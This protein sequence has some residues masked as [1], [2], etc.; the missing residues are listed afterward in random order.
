MNKEISVLEKRAELY[1]DEMTLYRNINS[2]FHRIVSVEGKNIIHNYLLD[3]NYHRIAFYGSGM[4]GKLLYDNL[5][6]FRDIVIVGFIDK[7]RNSEYGI[8]DFIDLGDLNNKNIDL[9]I[10]TPL[11]AGVEI[12]DELKVR[13]II[14]AKTVLEILD[15]EKVAAIY[16]NGI[17][18]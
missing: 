11:G 5:K 15:S 14:K 4:A 16:E 9:I 3:N 1:F 12:K 6:D 8:T 2:Y 10:I 17:F 13:N 18:V 7:N